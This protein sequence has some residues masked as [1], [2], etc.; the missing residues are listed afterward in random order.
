MITLLDQIKE[1]KREIALREQAYPGF[2]QR[3]RLT[4]GQA[5]WSL[6]AMRAALETLEALE[7]E[8]QQPSLFGTNQSPWRN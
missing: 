8:T 5:S 3:G 2:V 7:A 6:A 4:E 1:V